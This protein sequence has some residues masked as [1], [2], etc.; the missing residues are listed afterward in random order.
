MLIDPYRFAVA[1]S[2]CPEITA[3]ASGA[4]WTG[5]YNYDALPSLGHPDYSFPGANVG[6]IVN[7]PF[8]GFNIIALLLRLKNIGVP[9]DR[10]IILVLQDPAFS[11]I[12]PADFAPPGFD[13]FIELAGAGVNTSKGFPAETSEAW[14]GAGPW[15][16]LPIYSRI[17]AWNYGVDVEFAT[18]EIYTACYSESVE[19]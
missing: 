16:G 12:P 19:T 17:Y 3:A 13:A 18:G 5:Y 11:T 2:S 8:Q 10:E 1:S 9:D 6:S 14:M 7:N 15:S 4:L